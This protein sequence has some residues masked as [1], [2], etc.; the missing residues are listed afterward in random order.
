MSKLAVN[1]GRP[2]RRRPFP[3]YNTIG[4]EEIASVTRSLKSGVL[5]KFL[6]KWS[7]DF[8][9]GPLVKEFE[10]QWNEVYG[11][12]YTVSVNSATSGLYAAIGAL[13]IG[14]GDEVI[15]SPITMSATAT[16]IIVYNAVPVFA[17]VQ[18][19][20]FNLDPCSIEEKITPRTK[21]IAVTHIF[22]HPADMDPIME[23]A[24]RHGLKVIEDCAQAP[25]TKYKG[26]YVGTIGDIGV[27]S[28]NYHKHIHT[29][30]GGMVCT[31]SDLYFE[32]LALIRNHGELA[33]TARGLED[34]VNT[35]GFN[36]RLTEMQAA[37][38]IEQM[39]KLKKLMDERF[40]NAMYV[41]SRIG[42]LPGISS[43]VI[44]KDCDHAFYAQA[45]K[46]DM[47]VVGA[48]RSA[49]INAVRAE[50]PVTK[51]REEQGPLVFEGYV[52][53]LYLQSM[54][55]KQIAYGDKG[56][57]FKCPLYSGK[58]DYAKG[59]CPTAERLFDHELFFHEMFRPPMT[60][61]DLDDVVKAFYK[62][63]ENRKQ[64]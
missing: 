41:G 47:R 10:G 39:K 1:G 48:P 50:L 3:A 27:F 58:T 36:Y 7:S 56:C 20:I 59:I 31:N 34:I 62:V 40:S 35:F 63:Y 26:R 29:G 32:K 60:R 6:A 55:Q 52:R 44:Y 33:S 13:G 45:F 42:E 8:F 30:E 57:P 2:I 5:S 12:K 53:P 18:D 54:Y 9:G 16:A 51:L 22:G 11:S 49:F 4:R 28:L 19:D 14:P 38:G 43:P 23:I 37:V 15:V 17:D 21:A 61:K 64:L 24:Q 25:L 46:Y